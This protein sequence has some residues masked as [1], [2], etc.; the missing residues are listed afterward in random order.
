MVL[1]PN[2]TRVKWT[3]TTVVAS[4]REALCALPDARKGGN[5]Q[6]YA[7]GD[8]ALGAFSVFFIQSPSFLDFR[9]RM[10]KARGRNNACSLFGVEQLPSMQQIRTAEPF[11]TITT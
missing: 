2:S 3:A 7:M 11:P 4:I 5:N 1:K 6:R 10:Q 8:G 9:V